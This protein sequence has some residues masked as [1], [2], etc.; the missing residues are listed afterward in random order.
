MHNTNI[1]KNILKYTWL[2]ITRLMAQAGFG[3]TWMQ[4]QVAEVSNRVIYK[5]L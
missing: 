3:T 4:N 2:K 5:D 1:I